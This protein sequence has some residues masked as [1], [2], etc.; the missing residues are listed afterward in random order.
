ML[1]RCWCLLKRPQSEIPRG[2]GGKGRAL[3]THEGAARL[4]R[5]L[6]VGVSRQR[7]CRKEITKEPE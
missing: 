7:R 1:N 2:N 3:E 4:Q 5:G 6:R